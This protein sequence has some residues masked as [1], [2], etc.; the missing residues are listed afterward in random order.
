MD[1]QIFRSLHYNTALLES[2]DW[3]DSQLQALYEYLEHEFNADMLSHPDCIISVIRINFG[4]R[5]ADCF[6]SIL[7]EIMLA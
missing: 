4:D 5:P 2:L 7:K 6:T 1:T 3:N